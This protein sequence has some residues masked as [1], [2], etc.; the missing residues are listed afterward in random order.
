[1]FFALILARQLISDEFANQGVSSFA[2]PW[3]QIGI[4]GGLAFGFALLM[5][6]IPSRQAARIPIAAALRY[7]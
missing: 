3:L 7:E 4:I 1:V 2:V 6:L 5:T